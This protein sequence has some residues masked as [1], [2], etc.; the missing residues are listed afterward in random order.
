MK[1]PTIEDILEM[2]DY[3]KGLAENDL[4]RMTATE[5][6]ARNEE[7]YKPDEGYKVVTWDEIEDE[8]KFEFGGDEYTSLSTSPW[9]KVAKYVKGE[10]DCLEVDDAE[11][12][13]HYEEYPKYNAKQGFLVKCK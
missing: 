4:V 2:I 3:L 12:A 6:V 11:L 1:K 5:V 9:T 7:A 10:G 13:R 8:D